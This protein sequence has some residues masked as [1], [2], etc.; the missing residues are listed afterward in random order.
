MLKTK[1]NSNEYKVLTD[2]DLD[3]QTATVSGSGVTV[4]LYKSGHVVN[5][6]LSK[7]GGVA[8]S[9]Y[10]SGLC[11][12]PEGFRPITQ[13]VAYF[14]GISGSSRSGDGKYYI[15][16]DGQ[17]G[18]FSTTTGTIERIVSTCWITSGGVI[19]ALLRL[20]RKA[21]IGC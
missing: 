3:V 11:T 8:K 7:I 13:Q 15:N 12:I 19:K 1:A 17:V 21:V 16:A 2:T 4:T 20:V 5:A 10:N 6:T 9:G 18:I 14:L